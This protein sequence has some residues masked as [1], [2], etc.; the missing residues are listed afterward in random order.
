MEWN[1]AQMDCYPEVDGAKDVVFT[2]HWNCSASEVVGENTYN[3]Y[4]YGSVG[5][6]LNAEEG[7]TPYAELTKDQVVG[8]VKDVLGEETVAATEANVAQQIEDQKN[9]KVVSPALPW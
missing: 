4:V 2:V 8:W 1:I 7:F 9:P 6:Q 3:G 5:V